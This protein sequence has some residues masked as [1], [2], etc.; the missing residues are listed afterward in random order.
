MHLLDNSKTGRWSIYNVV[1]GTFLQ[2][3]S[4]I[5]SLS[6]LY[7][8]EIKWTPNVPKREQ[9]TGWGISCIAPMW[10]C[11]ASNLHKSPIAGHLKQTPE[12]SCTV[13]YSFCTLYRSV[14][15]Q[16]HKT[17]LS[18]RRPAWPVARARLISPILK[19]I[20]ISVKAISQSAIFNCLI[21][22]FKF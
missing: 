19:S 2:Y 8:S 1:T 15:Q 18:P 9:T 13:Q 17:T 11:L 22:I 12:L 16:T 7:N 10:F 14:V 4:P 21:R 3:L 20:H 5:Y 6:L